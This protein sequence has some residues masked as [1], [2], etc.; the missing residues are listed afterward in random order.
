M[1]FCFNSGSKYVQSKLLV[2]LSQKCK[3]KVCYESDIIVIKFILKMQD[4]IF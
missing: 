1:K 2:L 4:E 3:L